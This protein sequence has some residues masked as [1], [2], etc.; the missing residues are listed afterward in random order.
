ML[1]PRPINEGN[2]KENNQKRYNKSLKKLKCYNRKYSFNEDEEQRNK[3][4]MRHRKQKSKMADVNPA[5]SIKIINVDAL[6]NPIKRQRYTG[7]KNMT[8]P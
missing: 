4:D 8:Q 2:N 3:K 7:H 6:N 1:S 5:L